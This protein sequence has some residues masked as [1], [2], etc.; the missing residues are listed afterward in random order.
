MR[1]RGNHNPNGDALLAAMLV[2][3]TLNR[4]ERE[5]AE[6]EKVAAAAERKAAEDLGKRVKIL[7]S[8]FNSWSLQAIADKEALL[9]QSESALTARAQK[10]TTIAK[11]AETTLIRDRFSMWANPANLELLKLNKAGW[12]VTNEADKRPV[13]PTTD[14][15]F[16]AEATDDEYDVVT[17]L[18]PR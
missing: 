10:L 15:K 3:D 9:V 12:D 11:T 1:R 13:E 18:T 4:M 2:M 17:A 7:L 16:D 5:T 8:V 14:C 6:A